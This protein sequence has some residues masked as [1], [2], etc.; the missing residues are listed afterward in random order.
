[1]ANTP[2]YALLA[3][4]YLDNQE[5]GDKLRQA[6]NQ[7]AR[8]L[9]DDPPRPASRR[10]AD[11]KTAARRARGAV[12]ALRRIDEWTL[13][14]AIRRGV[15]PVPEMPELLADDLTAARWQGPPRHEAL[16]QAT[17][18]IAVMDT[19]QRGLSVLGEEAEVSLGRPERPDPVVFAIEALASIWRATRGTRPTQSYKAGGFGAMCI[20]LLT[21]PPVRLSAATVHQA[22]R[23]VLPR[24]PGDAGG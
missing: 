3:S 14:E 18:A 15:G 2:D 1:M 13:A 11:L 20:D 12:Q 23:Q 24:P 17:A 10:R 21:G 4:R 5:A 22:V 9:R 8:M 6:V 19:L 16:A 7:V